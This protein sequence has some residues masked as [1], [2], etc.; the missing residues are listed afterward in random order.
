M[1]DAGTQTYPIAD[2]FVDAAP[3]AATFTYT[4]QVEITQTNVST[5]NAV[6]TNLNLIVF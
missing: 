5:A 2:T 4:L 3:G 6:A 1:Q